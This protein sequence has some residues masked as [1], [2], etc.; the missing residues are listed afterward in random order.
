MRVLLSLLFACSLQAADLGENIIPA[1]NR[2]DWYTYT[3]VDGGIPNYTNI[4]DATDAPYNAVGNGI[5][6]DTAEINAALAAASEG[7]AVYLPA[8][9]YLTSGSLSIPPGVVLRGAGMDSTTIAYNASDDIIVFTGSG[10]TGTAKTFTALP[11]KGD[12]VVSLS[13]VTGLSVGDFILMVREHD[14]TVLVFDPSGDCSYCD[15]YSI[16]NQITNIDGNDI[17]LAIPMYMDFD[18][19]YTHSITEWVMDEGIGVEDLTIDRTSGAGAGSTDYGIYGRH[20]ANCWVKNVKSSNGAGPHFA[21]LNSYRVTITGCWIDD[22]YIFTS[23]ANYGIFFLDA[24]SANRV[25]DN[26]IFE[27]RHGIV[28][29]GGGSGNAYLYNFSLGGHDSAGY[30]LGGEL[31]CHGLHSHICLWEGNVAPKFAS[32]QFH[33]S[34][35]HQTI[36]RNWLTRTNFVDAPN[37]IVNAVDVRIWSY[38]DAVVGNVLLIPGMTSDY[39]NPTYYPD[40]TDH[41][42]Y[43]F[44]YSATSGNVSDTNSL[45]T[46]IIHRNYDYDNDSIYEDAGGYSTSLPD[47]LFY[48]SKPSYFGS[49][50]WPPIDPTSP[51]STGAWTNIIPASARYY[52]YDYE[53]EDPSP[54]TATVRQLNL[55]VSPFSTIQETFNSDGTDITWIY[56]DSGSEDFDFN[57][58]PAINGAYS[59][60]CTNSSSGVH[61]SIRNNFRSAINQ[62]TV[63]FSLHPLEYMTTSYYLGYLMNNDTSI[64]RVGFTTDGRL[65]PNGVGGTATV[66]SMSLD[67]TY[68][69]WIVYDK[70]A[71]TVDGSFSTGITRPTSGDNHHQDTAS[72]AL[73]LNSVML[74]T[75]H[76][77]GSWLVDDFTVRKGV[78]D[79]L[80]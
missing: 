57:Y 69:V 7:D 6:D 15:G 70:A 18:T 20:V 28:T 48:Q 64:S 24:S 25:E 13:N 22:G 3:G 37:N 41:L 2:F 61:D 71:G 53:T 72:A 44:G 36:Y 49:L 10:S 16:H 19:N 40:S 17:T 62:A 45:Y 50:T 14:D 31:L 21:F 77:P 59:L 63:T 32:D 29:E 52:G 27:T 80:P 11:R 43:R 38:Y 67:T 73:K 66:G 5:N 74:F 34:S 23:G 33:G 68:N 58:T 1:T 4:I 12:T 9:T 60:L 26:I 55:V 79:N 51:P 65:D 56:A 47:S 35:S 42:T 8:G 54:P 78:F 75:P 76:Y 39:Y 30:T 46:A